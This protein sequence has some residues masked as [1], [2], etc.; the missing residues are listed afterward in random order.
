M[1]SNLSFSLYVNACLD[2]LVMCLL[3]G[4]FVFAHLADIYLHGEVE[5]LDDVFFK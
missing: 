1:C 4:L 3:P 2:E 5:V